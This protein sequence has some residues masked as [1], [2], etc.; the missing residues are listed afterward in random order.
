MN[1]FILNLINGIV[2][3]I[4]IFFE[5]RGCIDEVISYLFNRNAEK[6]IRKSQ[7]FLE[8]FSYAK[9]KERLPKKFYIWYYA[10][11][12]YLFIFIL[13]MIILRSAGI[14]QFKF[15]FLIYFFTAHIPASYYWLM[16]R[17]L[18]RNDRNMENVIHKKHGNKRNR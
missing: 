14:Q 1:S 9:F 6:R 10:N 7:N 18:Y 13:F 5:T 2:A 17:G 8:W 4:L 16:V 15:A 11:F 12:V 3:F